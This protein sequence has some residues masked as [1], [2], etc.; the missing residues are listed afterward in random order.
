VLSVLRCASP[1]F[2]VDAFLRRFPE[3]RPDSVFRREDQVRIGRANTTSG[4]SLTIPERE[5]R[6]EALLEIHAAIERWK[7]IIEALREEGVRP[8]LDVS[9]FVGGEHAFVEGL[10]F[11]SDEL[12]WLWERGIE[13][14]ITAYPASDA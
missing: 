13:L 6:A 12:R 14:E 9:L 7:P 5:S 3:L 10:S 1:S 2:D 8:S 4:F 11:P